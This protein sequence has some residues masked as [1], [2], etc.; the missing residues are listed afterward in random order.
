M[1]QYSAAVNIYG[2]GPNSD[3]NFYLA[4]WP[5]RIAAMEF[6]ARFSNSPLEKDVRWRLAL[7]NS[8]LSNES[9]DNWIITQVERYLNEGVVQLDSLDQA[10]TLYGFEIK[11]L[12]SDPTA[13]T[14][15]C[16]GDGFPLNI[17]GL[18]EHVDVQI[19]KI[20]VVGQDVGLV[21]AV[22]QEQ[23]GNYRVFPIH[24]GDIQLGNGDCQTISA[25]DVTGDGKPEIIVAEGF[26]SGSMQ[27]SDAIIYQWQQDQ[28][29]TVFRTTI[30]DF[31]YSVSFSTGS[32]A[33][34]LIRIAV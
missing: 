24:S 28:F 27:R 22:V 6:L 16:G 3:L 2:P 8:L 30:F 26:A 21:V 1:D 5:I 12:V 23:S 25:Q 31:P 33:S 15:L 13:Y 17:S 11:S 34:T 18:F 9:S 14:F 10:L 20:H 4:Q 19:L 32:D 7:A 29:V